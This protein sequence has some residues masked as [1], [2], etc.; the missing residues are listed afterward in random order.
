MCNK[1][2]RKPNDIL[3]FGYAPKEVIERFR[4]FYKR[5][6]SLASAL[7]ELLKVGQR[8][9]GRYE[10]LSV[11]K[12][13]EMLVRIERH[14]NVQQLQESIYS[15]CK[16][17]DES[18]FDDVISVIE[19]LV[20]QPDV[21]LYEHTLGSIKK[22]Q[23]LD[24]R[25][26]NGK[27][28]LNSNFIVSKKGTSKESEK[29]SHEKIKIRKNE[30]REVETDFENNSDDVEN[31]TIQNRIGLGLEKGVC[32]LRNLGNSC[33]MNCVLQCMFKTVELANYFIS[34]DYKNNLN[35]ESDRD[36]SFAHCFAVLLKGFW[37]GQYSCLEPTDFRN[38]FREVIGEGGGLI[39]G[40]EQCAQE[41]CNYFLN[42]LH[43]HLNLDFDGRGENITSEIRRIFQL[44]TKKT[45]NGIEGN[46]NMVVYLPLDKSED[47]DLEDILAQ[48]YDDEERN[49]ISRL[50]P[51]II[52]FVQR[53]SKADQR[54]INFPLNGLDMNEYY[55]RNDVERYNLYGICNFI[56]LEGVVDH[57]TAKCKNVSNETWYKFDDDEW[58]E[59]D[60]PGLDD[61]SKV[62]IMFYTNTRRRD[63]FILN[64]PAS[65][66]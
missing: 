41:F 39:D 2:S 43:E 21:V 40:K 3:N 20:M 11:D 1:I 24:R 60:E 37:S 7:N 8:L 25:I 32:G 59:E 51:V 55:A 65:V 9:T 4:N 48:K 31:V 63:N 47:F 10:F 5:H 12:T 28:E 56:P 44:E 64:M 49:K 33:F 36:G 14:E 66:E 22:K 18:P 46:S 16:Y 53:H 54:R 23:V 35:L 17:V 15:L 27:V 42:G 52:F 61:R 30:K 57:Y 29:K 45:Y 50:P 6:C 38:C 62:F 58:I 26:K 34:N 19:E 13:H